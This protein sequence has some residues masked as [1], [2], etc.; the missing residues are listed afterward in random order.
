MH[1]GGGK[2]VPKESASVVF[3]TLE[4]FSAERRKQTRIDGNSLIV[5][6][7]Q[8]ETTDAKRARGGGHQTRSAAASRQAR[9][10]LLAFGMDMPRGL[11]FQPLDVLPFA[12]YSSPT[13]IVLTNATLSDCCLDTSNFSL[14][15]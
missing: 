15:P 11:V 7:L 12:M 2:A 6:C 4:L 10:R 8:P 13:L 9:H 1:C 5:S 14:P 3:R